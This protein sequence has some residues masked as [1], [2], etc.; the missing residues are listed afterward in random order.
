[1]FFAPKIISLFLPYSRFQ[2]PLTCHISFVF[3]TSLLLKCRFR[4]FSFYFSQFSSVW[5]SLKV[6][7]VCSY[8]HFLSF[9][10]GCN[11]SQISACYYSTDSREQTLLCFTVS[12]S[13][14]LLHENCTQDSNP[15]R[16]FLFTDSY[17]R[18]KLI[19]FSEIIRIRSSLAAEERTPVSRIFL[20]PNTQ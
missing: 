16:T 20:V 10:F 4:P 17:M 7:A 6:P 15:S 19:E 5:F 1:L 13:C 14:L 12:A 2:S 3:K 11:S 9:I 18:P 8:L